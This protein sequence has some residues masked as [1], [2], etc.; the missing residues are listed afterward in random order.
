MRA[1]GA[2]PGA[3]WRRGPLTIRFSIAVAIVL[4]GI[5][6]LSRGCEMIY[7]RVPLAPVP[8][9]APRSPLGDT[10]PPENK[11]AR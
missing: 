8:P 1:P 3:F 11:H 2:Q 10:A 5:L 7:A 9:D 6:L 4:F